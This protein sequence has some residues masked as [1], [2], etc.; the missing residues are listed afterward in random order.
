PDPHSFPLQPQPSTSSQPL[1]PSPSYAF[2]QASTSSSVIPG[3]GKD[4]NIIHPKLE[5]NFIHSQISSKT[6]EIKIYY[7]E[8]PPLVI[9]TVDGKSVNGNSKLESI[10]KI[11][12]NHFG[13]PVEKQNLYIFSHEKVDSDCLG[14]GHVYPRKKHALLVTLRDL[15][16]AVSLRLGEPEPSKPKA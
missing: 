8:A 1:L 15:N 2:P 9:K 12:A 6:P 10:K 16:E 14:N 7:G 11:I 3:F 13:I 5:S 4:D